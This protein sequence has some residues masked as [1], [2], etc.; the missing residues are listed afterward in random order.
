MPYDP[1]CSVGVRAEVC[2]QN[3]IFNLFFRNT[4]HRSTQVITGQLCISAKTDIGP[5]WW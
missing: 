2:N 3:A 4:G 1:F 5:A